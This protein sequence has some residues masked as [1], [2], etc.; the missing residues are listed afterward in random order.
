M[1]VSF[2]V[3]VGPDE[4]DEMIFMLSDTPG[5][6][7]RPTRLRAMFAMRACRRS[8]MIGTALSKSVMR[9]IVDHMET[10]EQPWNCPHGRPTMRHMYDLGNMPAAL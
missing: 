4:V 6:M 9:N 7:C 5:T 2:S 8:V 1:A 3:L 10:L